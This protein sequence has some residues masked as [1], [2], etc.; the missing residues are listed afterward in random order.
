[1]IA[2]RNPFIE[3]GELEVRLDPADGIDPAAKEMV[4]EKVYPQRM[5]LPGRHRAGDRITIP[6]DGYETALFELYPAVEAAAGVPAGVAYDLG[7]EKDG[8]V[9]VRYLPRGGGS[10]GPV[11]A[12]T[13]E[14]VKGDP[15]KCALGFELSKT[16]KQATLA[17]LLTPDDAPEGM[18]MPAVAVDYDGSS[19]LV[20]S[21]EQEGRSQWFTVELPSGVRTANISIAP[22][23]E[24]KAWR[25]KAQLW[26]IADEEL[27]T[28]TLSLPPG[29]AVADRPEPP[30]VRPAGS[31]RS[32][33]KLG[34]AALATGK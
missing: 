15:S 17:V 18:P 24:G 22:G 25:G 28:A 12:Q 33:V 9:T 14:P 6:L 8:S 5:I 13:V 20:R 34:T 23:K 1:M 21:E 4:V 11:R 3:K 30:R 7:R 10:S 27:P 29:A 26:L 19:G 16:T 31:V 32:N 2:A